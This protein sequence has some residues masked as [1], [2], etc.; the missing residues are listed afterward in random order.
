MS[1][2][3]LGKNV[4]PVK[5]CK[6][7]GRVEER[8]VEL[9]PK[10]EERAMR[11]HQESVVIDFHNH[12][13]VLPEDM[14]DHETLARSGR[15]VTGFE[16]IEKSGMTACFCAFGGSMGRRS[17]PVLWQFNDTIWDYGMRWADMHHHQ[18][19]VAK[20]FSVKDILE[21]KQ[22]GRCAVF[23]NIE[24]A[25]VIDNDLDRLDV[26]YGLGLRCVGVGFNNRTTIADGLTEKTD[27]GLSGFG[28]EVIERMNSLGILID[29]SHASPIASREAIEASK[30]PCCIS[31]TFARGVHNTPRGA[32]DEL[33]KLLANHG[34]LIGV[35]AVTNVLSNKKVQTVFDVIDHVDYLVKLVGIDH[36][37]IGT[38]TMFGDHVALHKHAVKGSMQMKGYLDES[39]PAP[40][41]DYIEN[42]SQWPNITRALVD[43]GYSDDE[44][45]KIIGGNLLRFLK[46]TIG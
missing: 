3:Y 18:D 15:T 32:S 1:Y 11:L 29:L 9:S 26:L 21:A 13:K 14:K 6:V 7:V 23:F 17:S 10:D 30:A 8:V 2:E 20:G 19:V 35:F 37:A 36:V 43:R 16:G 25:Q 12:L 33:C 41:T 22:S 5:L 4:I 34:G 27:C 40:Y 46:E 44:I 24:N 42:A 38:D 39:F 45:K 31:H 28:F